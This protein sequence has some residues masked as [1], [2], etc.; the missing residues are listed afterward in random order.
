[1]RNL[2]GTFRLVSSVFD[3]GGKMRENAKR[4]KPTLKR[5]TYTLVR[6]YLVKF[7]RFCSNNGS[8]VTRRIFIAVYRC[9]HPNS[10]NLITVIFSIA[11]FVSAI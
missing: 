2:Q 10:G 6:L 7:Y 11:G 4:E 5:E 3:H 8:D 9:E 1:M